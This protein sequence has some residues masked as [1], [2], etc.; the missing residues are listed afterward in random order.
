LP[1]S[2]PVLLMKPD[3]T[4]Y[5]CETWRSHWEGNTTTFLNWFGS[6][7]NY[8]QLQEHPGLTIYKD[9]NGNP[10]PS[11]NFITS[12]Y[13]TS[14]HFTN[15]TDFVS[16]IYSVTALDN[17]TGF[18]DNSVGF[19]CGPGMPMAVGYT[20]S[21]VNASDFGGI[22]LQNTFCSADPL[23]YFYPYSVTVTGMNFTIIQKP[24]S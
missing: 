19:A 4:A 24:S 16:I 20:A 8:S 17:S 11:H 21:Q 10:L 6:D 1:L 3:S 5:V 12:A 23:I 7:I 9:Y 13:P 14:Y 22:S 15:T 2:Y 18:Y